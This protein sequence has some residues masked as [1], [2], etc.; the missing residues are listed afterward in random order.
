MGLEHSGIT[1]SCH[2]LLAEQWGW[3]YTGRTMDIAT[4][5]QQNN[6]IV[7]TLLKQ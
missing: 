4:S 1:L 6:R 5:N 7:N 2:K 3:H